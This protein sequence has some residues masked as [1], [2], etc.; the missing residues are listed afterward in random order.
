MCVH[1]YKIIKFYLQMSRIEGEYGVEIQ[2]GNTDGENI[3]LLNSFQSNSTTISTNAGEYQLQMLTPAPNE[4][5]EVIIVIV[6]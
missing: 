5:Q 6:K 2:T 4:D 3:F 1:T